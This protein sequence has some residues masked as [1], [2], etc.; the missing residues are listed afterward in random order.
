MRLPFDHFDLIARWYDRLIT[1][2]ADDPLPGL[3]AVEAGHWV[4]DVGGG[5]GRNAYHLRRVGARV[6]VCD[7]AQGMVREARRKGLPAVLGSVIHL[8]FRA[9]SADRI[10]VVDA[11]HHFV[12]P[13]PETAQRL[14]AQELVRVLR[15]GGRLVIEE[16][17]IRH[18]GTQLIAVMERLLLMGSRFLAPEELVSLCE[19]AG[20]RALQVVRAQF[21]ALAVFTKEPG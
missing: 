15:P 3:L 21:S 18:A 14:A 5:T 9:D 4:L 10:L 1:R 8:P 7:A 20:A 17:D 16:P 12:L 6:V 2:P 13:S 11:F 19:A